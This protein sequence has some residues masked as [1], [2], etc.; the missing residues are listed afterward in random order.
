MCVILNDFPIIIE[1]TLFFNEKSIDVNKKF[2]KGL[3]LFVEKRCSKWYNTMS[4]LPKMVIICK[5]GVKKWVFLI[6]FLE[7]IVKEN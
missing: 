2:T 6:R 3:P 1:G 7:L 5:K 4:I